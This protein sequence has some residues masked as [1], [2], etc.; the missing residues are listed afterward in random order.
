MEYITTKEAAKKW[1]IPRN[2]KKP[3]DGRR[4]ERQA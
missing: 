2:A 3:A 4:K 1:L